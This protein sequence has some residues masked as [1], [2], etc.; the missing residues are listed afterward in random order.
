MKV[1]PKVA[2]INNLLTI[3]LEK[4]NH[5]LDQIEKNSLVHPNIPAPPPW[6]LNG[7]PLTLV[8]L[9]TRVNPCAARTSC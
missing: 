9:G 1:V 3:Q 7:S 8:M 2:E 4:N 6:T 5:E